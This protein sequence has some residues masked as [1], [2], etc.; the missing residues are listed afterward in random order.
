MITLSA[1]IAKYNGKFID[2]DRAWGPQCV[3]LVQEYL[4]ECLNRGP[5]GGNAIDE[6]GEDS[7]HWVWTRNDPHNL[8]QIPP[9]GSVMI[10]GRDARIGTGIYGHTAVVITSDRNGFVSFDQN[11][12][13]NAPCHPVKH[14]YLGIIGWGVPRAPVVVKPPVV[15]PSP[16]TK[17]PQPPPG[18]V[19]VQPPDIIVVPPDEKPAPPVVPSEP[20]TPTPVVIPTPTV[21]QHVGCMPMALFLFPFALLHAMFA[22]RNRR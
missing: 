8:G 17:P 14:S 13:L 15:N 9:R 16:V 6:Y 1:F 7:P 22:W 10:W 5:L 4:K 12:P 2:F 20:V 3:D 18:P 19:A 21:L 11:W